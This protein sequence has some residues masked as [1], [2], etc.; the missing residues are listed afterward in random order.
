MFTLF[1]C[2]GSSNRM[3]IQI[4]FNVISFQMTKKCA[5]HA[6]IKWFLTALIQQYFS[7]TKDALL[8][9]IHNRLFILNYYWLLTITLLTLENEDSNWYTRNEKGIL[10]HTDTINKNEQCHIDLN[11][12]SFYYQYN[13]SV[14]TYFLNRY[15]SMDSFHAPLK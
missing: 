9:N 14:K 11:I 15:L 5:Q 3:R 1:L 12:S 7:G 13:S 6:P 2:T 8:T 10:F 4:C